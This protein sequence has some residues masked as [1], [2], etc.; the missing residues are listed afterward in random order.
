[1]TITNN[2]SRD[3]YT[4]TAGQ[5][6]FNYTFKIFNGDELNVYVTPAGQ[7]P[8]DNSDLT[9]DYVVD[10]ATV[11]DED[12][13]FITFNTPLSAGDAVSI[14][15]GIP[16]DRTV[17]YQQNGDFLPVTVNND[18]DRQVAQIKQVLELARKAVVFGQASQGTSG[19]TSEAPVA[20]QF[21]RWKDDLSGFENVPLSEL[22]S[23]VVPADAIP[24]VF[25]SV[26]DLILSDLDSGFYA[27]TSGYYSAGDGGGAMYLIVPA[28]A[29]DGFGDHTLSNGNVA[30]LQDEGRINAR[31]YGAG[32]SSIVDQIQN[33]NAMIEKANSIGE[34]G[35]GAGV[36]GVTIFIPDGV[37]NLPNGTT[38]IINR[39]NIQIVGESSSGSVISGNL[40]TLFTWGDGVSI[41]IGGGL[42]NLKL[43]Y[44]NTVSASAVCVKMDKASRFVFEDLQ[45]KYAPK[46]LE[47]GVDSVRFASSINVV[48]V[49]GTCAN[50]GVPLF[51]LVSGAGFDFSQGSIFVEDVVVPSGTDPHDAVSGRS[52]ISATSESWDTVKISNV[53]TNRFWRSVNVVCNTGVNI[54]NWF[55]SNY[56]SD[57]NGDSG[58][59]FQGLGGNANN[60]FFDNCWLVAT[61]GASIDMLAATGLVSGFRFRGCKIFINGNNGAKFNGVAI[62]DVTIDGCQFSGQ[63]RLSTGDS[64]IMVDNNNWKV[65]NCTLGIDGQPSTGYIAQARYGIQVGVNCSNY[66]IEGNTADG[67]LSGYALPTHTSGGKDRRVRANTKIDGSDPEYFSMVASA[68]PPTGVNEFNYSGV[69]L[70]I[71]ARGGTVVN[72]QINGVT[73]RSGA[74]F[75][76][77]VPPGASWSMVY[78]VAPVVVRQFRD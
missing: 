51:D 3:E 17:D 18:N 64:V 71:Y 35:A 78:S 10:P 42:K 60:Y 72:A 16:Y 55:F 77:S 22:P 74:D 34:T 69:N 37:Y 11:G 20:K 33:F 41:V 49:Y 2:P 12:G 62:D 40:G 4:A 6:V 63:G 5:V 32:V 29:A 21:I 38:E 8:N 45:L 53:T 75:N 67:T 14:V 56:V 70:E 76:L 27:I 15:S 23:D 7:T 46:L 57:Y 25:N 26:A 58:F 59:R 36:A 19:L 13:G 43:R 54:S 48:N 66:I 68:P 52:F 61:D 50:I 44:D 9:T 47:M 28:Q 24:Y 73:V 30:V 1:M 65:I 39:D 31:H